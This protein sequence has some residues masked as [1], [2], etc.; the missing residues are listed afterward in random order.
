MATASEPE[1]NNMVSLATRKQIRK[2]VIITHVAV[3]VVPFLVLMVYQWFK[4]QPPERIRVRLIQMPP[5]DDSGKHSIVPQAKTAKPKAKP[6]KKTLKKVK[7]KPKKKPVKKSTPKVKPKKKIIKKKVKTPR[8]KP[9][10]KILS[11]NDIKISRDVVKTT[12][13]KKLSSTDLEKNILKN[14]QKVN[15]PVKSSTRYNGKVIAAYSDTVGL[16]LEPI[17]EQP[18]KVSLGGRLPEVTIKLDIDG[19]GRVTRARIIGRSGITAMDNSITKLLHQLKHVP[20]PPDKR[21]K[22]ITIIMAIEK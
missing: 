1:S 16:Y 8:A 22:S 19:N 10:R 5:A 2:T 11:A 18:D 7:Q 12:T 9:K 17:W 4:P 21:A 6:K 15:Y 13:R 20:P 3:V 14:W